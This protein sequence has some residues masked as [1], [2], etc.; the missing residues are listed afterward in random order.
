M[1]TPVCTTTPWSPSYNRYVGV[2]QTLAKFGWLRTNTT[3]A[4]TSKEVPLSGEDFHPLIIWR[5]ITFGHWKRPVT[6]VR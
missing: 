4:R 3:Q 2:K 6:A 1:I 5:G